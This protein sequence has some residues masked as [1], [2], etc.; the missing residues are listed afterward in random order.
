MNA[1]TRTRV[2]QAAA[3]LGYVASPAASSLASGRTM[4]IGVI[5]PYVTRWYFA[6]VVEGAEAQ[7][8]RQGYDLLLYGLGEQVD[9]TRRL[10]A[11]ATLHKRVDAVLVL[12]LA[13]D[14][15][16]V[17]VLRGL[18]VPVALVGSTVEGRGSV[19]VD[20]DHVARTA[21][22]HL[23][24]LGHTRIAHMGGLA[25]D[26]FHFPTPHDRYLGYLGALA[27]AG[28]AADPVLDVYGGWSIQGGSSA[29][30]GLLA[31]PADRRPTAVFAS[32]DE[33][34]MGA[35]SSAR[36][37]G[38]AVPG[39]LSVVGVDDHEMAEYVDLTTVRQPVPEQGALAAQLLIDELQGRTL[40]GHSPARIVDTELVVRGTTGP[41]TRAG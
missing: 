41:A 23:L 26:A 30:D 25:D 15:P 20:D 35:L 24:G 28:V 19:S 17:D 16:E 6:N 11:I 10:T 29:M 12:N 14:G 5:V 32:S 9:M 4:T 38:V 3:A 33:M 13:L 27:D 36:R 37:H 39:E 18:T 1:D 7:F 2:L 8:R 31:L 34:A 40:R 22:N 21:T